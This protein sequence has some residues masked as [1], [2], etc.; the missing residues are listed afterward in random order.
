[1]AQAPDTDAQAPDT[2]AQAP[3]TDAQAPDTDAATD[4]GSDLCRD[5]SECVLIDNCCEC[6]VG[7]AAAEVSEC[8]V[9]CEQ[10][11]CE[12]WDLTEADVSC[13][14]AGLGRNRCVVDPLVA[15]RC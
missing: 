14:A 11:Q 5:D 2:D 3:D 1:D 9:S 6:S 10:T 15:P 8:T 12:Q 4:L 7:L 13:E